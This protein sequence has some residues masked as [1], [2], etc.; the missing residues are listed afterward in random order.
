MSN[1]LYFITLILLILVYILPSI[2]ALF[3][4]EE[5]HS[6]CI[7]LVNILLGWTIVGW[8]GAL[9]WS[10]LSPPRIK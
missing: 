8:L 1:A 9:I 4:C 5:R 2:I 7:V 3:Y 10:I 6:L